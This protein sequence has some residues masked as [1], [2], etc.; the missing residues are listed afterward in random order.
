[1]FGQDYLV[2]IL[3]MFYV[4]AVT[5]MD[6]AFI[7][8]QIGVWAYSAK[9]CRNMNFLIMSSHEMWRHTLV[10]LSNV[11]CP[12]IGWS[13]VQTPHPHHHPN[14]TWPFGLR[15]FSCQSLRWWCGGVWL[16][17]P[18]PTTTPKLQLD[19]LDL[20]NFLVK[21]WGGGGGGG[22]WC[23]TPPTTTPKL[24]FIYI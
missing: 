14:S 6:G 10:I 17:T 13:D 1:M 22:V 19:F 21:V 20:E 2:T 3:L 15:N 11:E 24:N 4:S 7:G 5:W 12:R 8:F 18:P 23:Q 16:Q 9:M